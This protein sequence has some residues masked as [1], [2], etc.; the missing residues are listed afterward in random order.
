MNFGSFG[1]GDR[2]GAV[3]IGKDVGG[4]LQESFFLW[5]N[6]VGIYNHIFWEKRVSVVVGGSSGGVGLVGSDGV[7][8]V[9]YEPTKNVSWL[10]AI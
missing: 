6:F 7:G 2:A 1:V 9:V 3:V 5:E 8:F 4:K 10:T